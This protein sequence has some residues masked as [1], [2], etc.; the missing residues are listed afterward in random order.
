MNKDAPIDEAHRLDRR[1]SKL[2]DVRTA[3]E[4]LRK[5]EAA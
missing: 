5:E 1:A 4:S 2:D 3:L